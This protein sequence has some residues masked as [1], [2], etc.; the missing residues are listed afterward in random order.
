MVGS[1]SPLSV[2]AQ[3]QKVAGLAGSARRHFLIIWGADDT[4]LR[5]LGISFVL[6]VMAYS[7]ACPLPQDLH[8]PRNCVVL[9]ERARPRRGYQLYEDSELGGQKLQGLVAS[10][11]SYARRRSIAVVGEM[12]HGYRFR[13]AL[14]TGCENPDRI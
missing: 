1:V 13:V 2:L 6:L 7:R 12:A 14:A 5:R 10:E 11:L 8:K 4:P 9:G 3:R